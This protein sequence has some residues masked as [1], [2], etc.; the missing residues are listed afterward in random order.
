M[1]VSLLNVRDVGGV[2]VDLGLTKDGV[3]GGEYDIAPKKK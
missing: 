2:Y 3:G 1:D